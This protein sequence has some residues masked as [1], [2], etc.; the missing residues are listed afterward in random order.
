MKKNYILLVVIA[1]LMGQMMFSSCAKKEGMDMKVV[2]ETSQKEL[3]VTYA[4]N[5]EDSAFVEAIRITDSICSVDTGT[6][7]NNFAKVWG[8]Y[9]PQE[10][11]TALF[12][13]KLQDKINQNATNDEVLAALKAEYAAAVTKTVEVLTGRLDD[14][15]LYDF[16]VGQSDTLGL[17]TLDLEGVKD[18]A[19]LMNVI[20]ACGRLEFWETYELEDVFAYFDQADRLLKAIFTPVTKRKAG[21]STSNVV[22]VADTVATDTAGNDAPDIKEYYKEHPLFA[23]LNMSIVQDASGN[24]KPSSG[25]LVGYCKIKDTARVNYMMRFPA[26]EAVF[27]RDFRLAWAARPDADNKD[28]LQLIAIRISQRDGT[29]Y[30][31]GTVVTDASA[32]EAENDMPMVKI[33]MNAEGAKIWQRMTR[34]NINRSIAIMLDGYV[35]SYPNVQSEI[36]EGKSSITGNFTKEEASDLAAIIKAGMMPLSVRVIECQTVIIPE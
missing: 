15:D 10:R 24:S 18:T 2:L 12:F 27:P 13:P 33:T 22:A 17:I 19:R 25:P 35:Y 8:Q 14:F 32:D 31:S 26:V 3:L 28:M 5:T 34:E 4:Y 23:K 29:P 20:Q 6:Y 30:L 7:L 11:L 1:L 21:D 36:A 9:F 16:K